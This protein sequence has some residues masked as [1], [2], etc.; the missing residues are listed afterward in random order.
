MFKYVTSSGEHF[1]NTARFGGVD[2]LCRFFLLFMLLWYDLSMQTSL[3][4]VCLL[5]DSRLPL[6]SRNLVLFW[7][8]PKLDW[9]HIRYEELVQQFFIYSVSTF[10]WRSRDDSSS[11]V[12]K[13]TYKWEN[14]WICLGWCANCADPAMPGSVRIIWM[15]QDLGHLPAWAT[16]Q[17]VWGG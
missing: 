11:V 9:F 10:H 13:R 17:A 2:V 7:L 15:G 12:S 4:L 5:W 14:V 8:L 3:L 16:K 1:Y 6:V